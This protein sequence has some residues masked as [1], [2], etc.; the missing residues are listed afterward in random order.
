MQATVY[1]ASSLLS[2]IFLMCTLY[3]YAVW[4]ETKND[5]K[6][7]QKKINIGQFV[8]LLKNEKKKK[9]TATKMC[10]FCGVFI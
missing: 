8:S 10:G 1:I 4:F 9:A 3:N 7:R 2:F 5:N 6:K